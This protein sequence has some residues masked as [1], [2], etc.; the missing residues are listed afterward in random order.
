MNCAELIQNMD[1]LLWDHEKL[2]QS[3]EL[4]KLMNFV[5]NDLFNQFHI[6][7]T[8]AKSSNKLI[9]ENPFA[10]I[11]IRFLLTLSCLYEKFIICSSNAAQLF[12]AN[13]INFNNMNLRGIKLLDTDLSAGSFI[14][15]NL[16]G[17]QFRRVKLISGSFNRA[18]LRNIDWAEIE[19]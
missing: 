4:I 8:A 2:R 11:L 15:T 17:S 6:S 19:V 12:A 9:L 1:E 14:R 10:L 16:E 13:G 3:L 7:Y 18:N 5:E